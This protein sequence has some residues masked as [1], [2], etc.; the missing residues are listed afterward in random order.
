MYELYLYLNFRTFIRNWCY[1]LKK[2]WLVLA[3]A[4]IFV[5]RLGSSQIFL[6]AYFGSAQARI[7]D[8]GYWLGSS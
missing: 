8:K 1:L 2:Y 7:F 4:E 3:R 5:A 6:K